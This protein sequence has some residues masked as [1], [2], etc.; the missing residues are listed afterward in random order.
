MIKKLISNI[1]KELIL[2]LLGVTIEELVELL[3]EL[4]EKK[5]KNKKNQGVTPP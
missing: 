4:K 2:E 3:R 1:L 5:D